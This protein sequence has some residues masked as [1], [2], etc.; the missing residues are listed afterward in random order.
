M[1]DVGACARFFDNGEA[2]VLV[3]GQ[4]RHVVVVSGAAHHLYI[5]FVLKGR[6]FIAGGIQSILKDVFQ[7]LLGRG[8]D[9]AFRLD[10]VA[11]V[12]KF[13]LYILEVHYCTRVHKA[14]WSRKLQKLPYSVKCILWLNRSSLEID[15]RVHVNIDD[16]AD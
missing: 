8:G 3:F 15:A 12:L 1:D 2:A 7:F 11:Q 10:A 9:A 4:D 6:D 13:V 14:P 5:Q 16:I